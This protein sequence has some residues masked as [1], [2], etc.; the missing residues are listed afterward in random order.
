MVEPHHVMEVMSAAGSGTDIGIPEDH[1]LLKEAIGK[2]KKAYLLVE[3]V[4]DQDGM[5]NSRTA[6]LKAPPLGRKK[7]I[8]Q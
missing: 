7:V 4:R 5:M 6:L 8:S 1:Q 2:D 3:S